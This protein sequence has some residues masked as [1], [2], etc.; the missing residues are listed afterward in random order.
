MRLIKASEIGEYVFCERAW[1]LRHV[2]GETPAHAA[3][4][5]HGVLA[6][7]AH[8]HTVRWSGRLALAG[9]LLLL[10]SALWLVASS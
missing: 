3:R 5:A 2:V 4:R 6:H 1:W 9:G 8:E 10:L 7:A